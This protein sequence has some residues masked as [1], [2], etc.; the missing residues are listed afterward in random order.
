MSPSLSV[1]IA[2]RDR[3]AMLRRCLASL[4]RQTLS[5]A[6]FEVVV[7]DDG[8]TDGSALA[9]ERFETPFATKVLRLAHRGK[10]WA[11]NDAL[12]QAEAPVCVF[13]DDDLIAAERL[14]E[15]HAEAHAG[16]AHVLGIGKLLQAPPS[17]RDRYARA[18]A[19]A[20]DERQERLASGEADW[21][22]CYG[23]N[24]SAPLDVLRGV[25]GFATD[26]PAAEDVE[27]AYR[28]QRAGCAPRFLPDAE[29]LHDDAKPGPRMLADEERFGRVCEL[30]VDRHPETRPRLLG[31]FADGTPREVALRRL[32]LAL[33][34]SPRLLAAAGALLPGS[35]RRVW[36]GFVSRLAFWRGV[37]E[38]TDAG[39]WRSVTR[40]I[41]VLMYHA[42]TA[43]RTGSR[44]VMPRRA[45]ARQMRL[46]RLLGYRVIGL[47]ELAG[48]LRTGQ[49]LPR[50][51]V[52]ITIDDGY[53][54][55]HELAMP[56]LRRR[57]FGATVFL[58][59]RRIGGESDWGTDP[60]VIG[61]PLLS[62]GEIAEMESAGIAFGAHTRTHPTLPE[63]PDGALADEVEGCRADLQSLLSKPVPTFAY[64]YGAYDD[65]SVEA[66]RAAGFEAACSVMPRPCRI[67]DDPLLIPRFEI[68]GTDPMRRFLRKLWFGD[69]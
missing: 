34:A 52:V 5:A 23:A 69:S 18:F 20:W 56:I 66:V 43:E 38:T 19:Q 68:W 57:G 3:E 42:F 59:S 16:E 48:L 65:A 40:G 2:T 8:S 28:L 61:R 63:V 7:A 47:E 53:R 25:G 30:I 12:E 1:V 37:R 14:L 26:L 64:P 41:P 44:F 62:P 15:A 51:S 32:L 4:A 22:E 9:A 27:I 6:E 55:N 24:F 13:L 10:A 39:T 49:A 31:W 67:V 50:R 54:D 29:A 58:V 36:L 21:R 17:G 45:F 60:E 33:R 46:L 11:L 35:A